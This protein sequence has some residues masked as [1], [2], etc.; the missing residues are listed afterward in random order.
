MAGLT[1]SP[2]SVAPALPDVKGK[3]PGIPG[4]AKLLLPTRRRTRDTARKV[5]HDHGPRHQEGH[6]IPTGRDG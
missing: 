6:P 2:K 3:V 4:A 5:T 1:A